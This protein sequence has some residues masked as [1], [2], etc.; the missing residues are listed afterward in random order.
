MTTQLAK[1]L[2]FLVGLFLPFC[3]AADLCKDS[4]PHD[5]L[6]VFLV[7]VT[8]SSSFGDNYKGTVQVLEQQLAQKERL[9]V[10]PVSDKRANS[11]V[12]L[13]I[14]KPEESIWES[15][16]AIMKRQK[17]YRD[18]VG[19]LMSLTPQKEKKALSSAILETLKFLEEILKVSTANK[20]RLV[21]YSDMI[22]NSEALSLYKI[23]SKDT[24]K[25]LLA[26]VQ[27]KHLVPDLK[28][29]EI[30]IAGIGGTQTD[31]QARITEEFWRELFAH[32]GASV[33]YYGPVLVK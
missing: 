30:S 28:G 32:A 16:L 21:I 19:S 14:V 24:A 9:L 3:A 11:T 6:T 22:Q 7:D 2:I 29:I 27:E 1:S 12:L 4:S 8:E 13:D 18:C 10:A 15:K 26:K 31:T 17:V 20:K 5:A 25:T 23:G 33:K